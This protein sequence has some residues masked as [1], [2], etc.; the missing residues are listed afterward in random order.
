M[1]NRVTLES[2]T[3]DFPIYDVSARSLRHRLV[4][5]KVSN[6]IPAKT[7][8]VG[9]NVRHDQQ[10]IVIVRA[11]DSVTF[12]LGEGDRVGVIGHN[13]AGKTT[14][15][16][17]VAGIF[18]PTVGEVRTEGRVM[19][20]FNMMEG[21]VPDATGIEMVRVRG[22]LLGLSDEEIEERITEIADFC[23]LGEYINM[24]VRTY[25]TGMLVR[26]AFAIT[27]SVTSEILIMDEFIGTGDAA[28]MERAET[29]LKGFLERFS[30]M[31]V[32]THAAAI[33]R[34][35]CNK[36]ILLEHGRVI[37]FG[38][39]DGVLTHYEQMSKSHSG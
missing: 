19:P 18:E 31:L 39:V 12:E 27:T 26:L 10:G 13:G 34:Q 23:E 9:G 25:S 4:L 30:V 20:L 38:P 35:W 24:P 33:V 17:V 7:A 1:A 29:R 6:L 28:F 37:D 2:V 8:N 3:L 32:A 5:D 14:L 21:M 11:L 36:A 22:T 16:R 15:L